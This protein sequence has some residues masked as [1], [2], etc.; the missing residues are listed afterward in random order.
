MTSAYGSTIFTTMDPK[1]HDSLVHLS[2]PDTQLPDGG[3]ERDTERQAKSLQSRSE[4]LDGQEHNA[5]EGLGGK[6][7][8]EERKRKVNNFRA[9]VYNVNMLEPKRVE[10]QTPTNDEK[11]CRGSLRATAPP[12]V[13]KPS[14][15]PER[16]PASLSMEEYVRQRLTASD[17]TNQWSSTQFER[18]E[19]RRPAEYRQESPNAT[20]PSFQSSTLRPTAPSFV[21]AA[22]QPNETANRHSIS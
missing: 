19:S 10:T 21:S 6:Q 11:S 1:R 8:Q 16:Q 14:S 12:F 17:G 4:F 13:P 3:S 15:S 18:T 22:S 7:T 5:S 9:G 2:A 20:E